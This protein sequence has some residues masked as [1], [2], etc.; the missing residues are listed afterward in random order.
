MHRDFYLHFVHG[1]VITNGFK[2]KTMKKI[3]KMKKLF[4][5][6][7]L[8]F[9]TPLYSEENIL[10]L[11]TWGG[12]IPESIIRQFEKETGI[13]V[14]AS[15]YDSNETLYAKLRTNRHAGYDVIQPSN[16][17]VDR[18]RKQNM[19]QKL[20]KKLLPHFK[21][22]NPRFLNLPYDPDNLYSLPFVWATT[23]LFMNRA[24]I[25]SRIKRFQDLWNPRFRNQ[26]LLL[27]DVREVFSMGLKVLG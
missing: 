10:N 18:M 13:K 25:T 8:L 3:K 5:F 21:N 4:F 24:I 20:D 1:V 11:Y 9:S 27:N 22:L 26:V 14:N 6:L 17:Y 7:C 15:T 16:Y 2:E 23:G 12:L 19:L